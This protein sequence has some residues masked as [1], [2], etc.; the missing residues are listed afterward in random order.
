MGSGSSHH[1]PLTT[2][3]SP[4]IGLYT[5]LLHDERHDA[6]RQYPHA[7]APA[8][9]FQL[10]TVRLAPAAQRPHA[11]TGTVGQLLFRHCFHNFLDFHF[12]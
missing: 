4:L 12:F 10:L 5:Q 8:H 2:H 11:D 1:S 6:W 9:A 7:W 3:L